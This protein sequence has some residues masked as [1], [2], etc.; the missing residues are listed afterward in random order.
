MN[1]KQLKALMEINRASM[2]LHARVN[3]WIMELTR[4]IMELED[5]D[6]ANIVAANDLTAEEVINWF[7]EDM[8]L[9]D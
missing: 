1:D 6:I 2:A 5:P 8:G 7:F 9:I 4:Q 3:T